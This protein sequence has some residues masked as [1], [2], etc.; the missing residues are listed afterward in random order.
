[1]L[2]IEM[3]EDTT[4]ILLDSDMMECL[5]DEPQALEFFTKLPKSHQNYYSK[6]IAGAKTDE[7]KS[8]RIA[9]CIRACSKGMQ[10]GEMMRSLKKE[11]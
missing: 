1:M 9:L 3:E 10:F 11:Q 7:T 2:A 4:P 6:W 8:K 5:E